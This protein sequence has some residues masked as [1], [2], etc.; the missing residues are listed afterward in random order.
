MA[1]IIFWWL[2]IHQ[3]SR[4]FQKKACAMHVPRLNNIFSIYFRLTYFHRQAW[5][6]PRWKELIYVTLRNMSWLYQLCVKKEHQPMNQPKKISNSYCLL[7][8][9]VTNCFNSSTIQ[10]SLLKNLPILE[11]LSNIQACDFSIFFEDSGFW[12]LPERSHS[13]FTCSK[14]AMETSE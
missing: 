2:Q 10:W 9:W 3:D 7:V 14:S 13:A 6:R 11:S 5:K 12:K 8:V 1:F 4:F